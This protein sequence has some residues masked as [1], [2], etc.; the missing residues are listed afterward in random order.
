[1]SVSVLRIEEINE[2]SFGQT[3]AAVGTLFCHD[4]QCWIAPSGTKREM[5]SRR[6]GVAVQLQGLGAEVM[7]SPIARVTNG[8]PMA[9]I[10]EVEITGQL[11]PSIDREYIA[12]IVDVTSVVF[13]KGTEQHVVDLSTITNVCDWKMR[14]VTQCRDSAYR[15]RLL[16]KYLEQRKR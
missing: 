5:V 13:R 7:E 3:V 12:Q 2:K 11:V 10:D 15:D 8:S 16:E 1:M 4:F 6:K 9:S 14:D